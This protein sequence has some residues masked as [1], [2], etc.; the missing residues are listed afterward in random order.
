[1]VPPLVRGPPAMYQNRSAASGTSAAR[2][3]PSACHCPGN[4][5]ASSRVFHDQVADP[6]HDLAASEGVMRL[7]GRFERPPSRSHRTI[8]VMRVALGDAREHR[9]GGRVER[10]EGPSALGL[11]EFAVDEQLAGRGLEKP[12][13]LGGA[14]RTADVGAPP[15]E[16]A[17]GGPRRNVEEL[18]DNP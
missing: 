9:V 18:A 10:V 3:T 17:F 7:H 8:D 5:L 14:G 12:S 1:M 16:C 4:E 2:A 6:V 13:F 15:T 11:L